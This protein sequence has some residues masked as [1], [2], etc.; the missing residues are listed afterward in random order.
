MVHV[1]LREEILATQAFPQEKRRTFSLPICPDFAVWMWIL[2]ML[3]PWLLWAM[4][5][6]AFWLTALAGK[7]SSRGSVSSLSLD[8]AATRWS[9]RIS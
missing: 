8:Q 4:T 6:E 2:E 9:G 7:D 5:D 1:S 3:V